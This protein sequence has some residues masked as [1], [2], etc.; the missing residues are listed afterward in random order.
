MAATD[1][2]VRA[3]AETTVA[4][5]DLQRLIAD[6]TGCGQGQTTAM[7]TTVAE[8]QA[9]LDQ[10]SSNSKRFKLGL[11]IDKCRAMIERQMPTA[12]KKK[13]PTSIF[14][15][16]FSS[17]AAPLRP[18]ALELARRASRFETDDK[19]QK[20][21]PGANLTLRDARRRAESSS[22][23]SLLSSSA[24]APA[25]SPPAASA[26]FGRSEAL[27]KPYLRLT[28]LPTVADVRPPRVLAEALAL[29]K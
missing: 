24:A 21:R 1:P 22:S 17:I 16:P 9:K 13:A 25:S 4:A 14:S 12:T 19:C 5:A 18:T 27:E 11:K 29:L 8:L 26:A 15:P 10:T 20:E 28:S 2:A 3:E 7:L 23:L 6:L